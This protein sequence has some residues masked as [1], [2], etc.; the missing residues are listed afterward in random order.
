MGAGLLELHACE[1]VIEKTPTPPDRRTAPR[2]FSHL[3]GLILCVTV[4][5]VPV[6]AHADLEEQIA[7]MT[8]RIERNPDNATLYLRRAELHRYHRDRAAAMSDY[9]RARALD[10]TLALVDL[11]VG[12]LE[13]EVGEPGQALVALERFLIARP[14]DSAGLVFRGRARAVLGDPL[15]AATDFDQAIARSVEQGLRPSPEIYIERA[16]LLQGAGAEH[17]SRAVDGLDAGAALL[18]RPITLEIEAIALERLLGRTDGALARVDRIAASSS[19]AEPWLVMRGEIL[20]EAGRLG[21]SARAY[22]AALKSLEGRPAH[23]RNVPALRNLEQEAKTALT[24][25]NATDL[26]TGSR[27]AAR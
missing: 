10:S 17:F 13:L 12:K 4:G 6:V 2:L 23:R 19:R 16:R 14:G 25:L 24:R 15:A 22:A 9:S 18:G 7:R 11:G 27:E 5:T 21:E 1:N 8:R 20:E 3:L 26:E